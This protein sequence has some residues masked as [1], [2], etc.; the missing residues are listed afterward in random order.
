MTYIPNRDVDFSLWLNNFGLQINDPGYGLAPADLT[1][2]ENLIGNQNFVEKLVA[3][4]NPETRTP[5]TVQAK[6]NARA[7]VEAGLRPYCV[8]ISMDSAISDSL[9]VALGV[10]VRKESPTP[11]PA[12][13]IAPEISL[14]AATPLCQKLQIRPIGSTS[15]AKPAGCVAI[16]LARSIGTVAA[17]DPS[18]LLIVGQYGKT[19]LIAQYQA[20]DQG[21]VVTYAARYRTRSG[22]AGVSQAGPW[23]ALISYVV[24]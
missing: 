8:Q 6:D 21:K 1:A 11:V 7:A 4:T 10:T 18:Q 19:P 13:T 16:E 15:K 9:K 24:I 14:V 22:P 2:I 17:T 3:A 20:G 5:V 12:P 23:S